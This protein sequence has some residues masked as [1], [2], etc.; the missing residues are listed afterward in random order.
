MS[1]AALNLR[2][3]EQAAKNWVAADPERLAGWL[4]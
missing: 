1:L 3:T 4:Q 2:E